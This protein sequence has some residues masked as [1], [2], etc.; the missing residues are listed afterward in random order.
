MMKKSNNYGRKGDLSFF[1]IKI[2]KWFDLIKTLIH[3]C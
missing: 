1:E 3:H 2:E